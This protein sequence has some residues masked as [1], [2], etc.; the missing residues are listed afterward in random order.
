MCR[1]RTATISRIPSLGEYSASACFREKVWQP[2][3]AIKIVNNIDSAVNLAHDSVEGEIEG[4]IEGKME[5]DIGGDI[6]GDINGDLNSDL[7]SDLGRDVDDD[8]DPDSGNDIDDETEGDRRKLA[9]VASAL[10]SATGTARR[11][12]VS[13]CLLAVV[14][15]HC[16]A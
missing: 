4:E 15:K 6:G 10:K 11:H 1:R 3:A 5:G 2:I 14:S 13:S 9:I 8:L 7:D 12:C 16:V